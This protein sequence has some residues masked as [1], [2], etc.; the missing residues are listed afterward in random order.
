MN[1]T[2]F[3]LLLFIPVLMAFLPLREE[4]MLNPTDRELP[5][6]LR[7]S[8]QWALEK[9]ETLSLRE[10]IAQSFMIAAYP[11]KDEKHFQ[12]LDDL[13]LQQKIGGLIYF[14][15][16]RVQM[17]RHMDRVKSL[18][19]IPLLMGIDAEWGSAMRLFNEPR[20]PYALTI[21]AANSPEHTEVIAEAMG[22]ELREL[23]IHLNFAPVVDVNS[24][25]NNPVIGFRSF[26]EDARKVGLQGVAMIK[27]MESHQVLTCM[28]HF[29]GH[30]D[31]DL[32]SHFDLPTVNRT[33]L[34]MDVVDW[35]PFKMGRLAGASSVM[36]AHLN[37]PALDSSGTP[38]S[39]SKVVIQDYLIGRL[40]F[41]GLIISD[42]LNMKAVSDR[43]GKVEVAKMAYLAG[44]D[45]LLYPEDVKGAIDA[46]ENAVL[47]GEILESEVDK[48]CIKILRA[49]YYSIIK[50]S[51][52][53]KIDAYLL[54]N[55]KNRIYENAITVLKNE[56]AIPI[57]RL[58]RK[59]AILSVG[60]RTESFVEMVNEYASPDT[61]H[62]FTADEALR[63]FSDT[64]SQYDVILVN[65]HAKSMLPKNGYGFPANWQ[66]MVQS[67]PK[68][69]SVILSFFGNPY[70][71][72][73]F[74][75]LPE[76]DAVV[77]GYENHP[78][79][80]H[81]T[82]QLLFGGYS[83]QGKLPVT[84]NQHFPVEFGQ[85]TPAASR[86]KYTQPEELG[87][88]RAKLAEIDSLAWK[89]IREK[90][91][92]GC[93]IVAA[94]DGKVFYR[95]SFGYLAYDQPQ[96]V[97][98]A[99]VYDMASIT[100]I[101]ASTISLMRLNDLNMFSLDSTLHSYIPEI[102]G[103]TVYSKT[104]LKDMMTHQ[105]GFSPWIPF[106]TKTMESGKLKRH[107]YTSVQNDSMNCK[108]ADSIYILNS[109]EDTMIHRILRTPLKAKSYKYSDLG[110]YFNKRIIENL[111][112]KKMDDFVTSYFYASMGLKSTR[113]NPLNFYDRSNISPTEVD[114]YYRNQVIQGYVHDMGAAMQ[115]GVGGHAGLFSNATDL[116][117]LMQM[118]LNNGVYGGERYLSEK[119]IKEYTSCQYCPGNRRG[120]GFDKPVRSLDGG[121]TCNR[122]SLKSYGHS[123]FTGTQVW[124]DPEHGINYVFLSNRTYPTAE[125]NKLLKMGIRTEVQRVIYEAVLDK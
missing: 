96:M 58:D 48:K 22:Q 25:P 119:V 81:W 86:L 37:V 74:E 26:G 121:P 4:F 6:F 43:F 14:Q 18:S 107:I 68:N 46:I 24:N 88:K 100:K 52:I 64:L 108:V 45:I 55:S 61:F 17:N 101:A 50:K 36:M 1:R 15:G 70:V 44:N 16:D 94:K 69:A 65:L 117:A 57:G 97:N 9:L 78:L 76:V 34:E 75:V 42:A 124:A 39:L 104:K 35:T 51:P 102:T 56:K 113:Y 20:F 19:K 67:L 73:D 66:R 21:G 53:K 93:Q 105:A 5:Y 112:K 2:S 23:G 77:M 33:L 38:S 109:Y 122:V 110:Y 63:R 71:L 47:N 41:S 62:A 114:S 95:K 89:G 28:K 59:L 3:F 98:N 83:A 8:P 54:E 7:E 91:Y 115:G 84:L 13:I 111:S 60:S 80:Q 106:Y 120:A 82:A 103:G 125:N 29:P 30:G 31:T 10:K 49:K 27:G 92:P 11:N 79:A 85:S 87:I 32:D 118:L 99:T 40:K 123:G 12:E 90:A 72:S 116:A